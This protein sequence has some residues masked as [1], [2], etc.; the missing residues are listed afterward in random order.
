MLPRSSVRSA[1]EQFQSEGT[2]AEGIDPIIAR[3]WKR[4]RGFGVLPN[5]K[6]APKAESVGLAR[7][8]REMTEVNKLSE[9]VLSSA[10]VVLRDSGCMIVMA[11]PD[12]TVI[13]TAGDE[14]I[15]DQGHENHLSVGGQWNEAYIGTNAIGTSIREKAPSLVHGPQH[16]C[17]D[18]QK[19][20]CAAAPILDPIDGA[21][22]GIL[23]ISGAS[24]AFLPQNFAL[25]VSLAEQI[26][27]LLA[28]KISQHHRS[29]L[30]Q[31]TQLR[32]RWGHSHLKLFDQRGIMIYDT[33]KPHLPYQTSGLM[34]HEMGERLWLDALLQNHPNFDAEPIVKDKNVIGALLIAARRRVVRPSKPGDPFAR[35]IGET[36]AIVNLKTKARCAASTSSPIM[37]TGEPG[38]GR[39]LLARAIHEAA[40]GQQDGITFVDCATAQHLTDNKD[41]LNACLLKET[42]CLDEISDH[43]TEFQNHILK[44]IASNKKHSNRNH[45]RIIMLAHQNLTKWPSHGAVKTHRTFLQIPPLRER[46]EDIIRLANHIVAN[47]AA[48]AKRPAPVFSSNAQKI[49]HSYHWPG[50]IRELRVELT[51]LIL[52]CRGGVIA[53]KDLP[54][55][56]SRPAEMAAI[57]KTTSEREAIIGVIQAHRG[58]MS[59]AARALGIARS[60][61]YLKLQTHNISQSQF[62]DLP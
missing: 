17:E 56:F 39:K 61:L 24:D 30:D 52:H 27:L 14:R 60:T 50:N 47:T 20:S 59:R 46:R 53:A 5:I 49:L 8:F 57:P 38:T 44:H 19:W 42:I 33:L 25:A 3:S 1:W 21:L 36:D 18:I 41:A 58:N 7:Q 23:D 12:G 32:A 35:F 40:G 9:R 11:A 43:L 29:L 16:F 22:R 45:P 51:S 34:L 4:A 31:F 6:T 13:K 55:H 10:H 48:L 26:K 15:I 2:L 28:L 37:I 62:R 54:Q